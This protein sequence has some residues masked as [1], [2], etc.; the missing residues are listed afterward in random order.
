MEREAL[1]LTPT[2]EVI[3]IERVRVLDNFPVI[4]ERVTLPI[5]RFPQF[6]CEFDKIPNTLYEHYQMDFG[7][8]VARA[9][10]QLRAIL[11]ESADVKRLSIDK[12]TPL[13][14][15]CRTTFDL[16]DQP[17]EFRISRINT[18]HHMY[19]GDLR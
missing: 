6:S 1:K 5:A 10:E 18:I 7:I 11:P 15:V 9:T 8:T 4:N 17:V 19:R 13:L 3:H 16:Q 2:S 12:K 14:Q